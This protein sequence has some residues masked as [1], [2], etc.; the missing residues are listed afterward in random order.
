MLHGFA[1]IVGCDAQLNVGI[2]P[3]K[4]L[5]NTREQEIAAIAGG[6]DAQ[7]APTRIT[8]F[9]QGLACLSQLPQH[10][11]RMFEKNLSGLGQNG[12]LANTREHLDAK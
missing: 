12:A 9:K 7:P 11:C 10:H 2:G 3:L 6:T 1:S 8:Q 5:Q 4:L